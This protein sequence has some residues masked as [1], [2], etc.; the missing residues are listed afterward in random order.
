MPTNIVASPLGNSGYYQLEV[1]GDSNALSYV[2]SLDSME[3]KQ[4]TTNT[5]QPFSGGQS[6]DIWVKSQGICDWSQP[7]RQKVDIP[8]PPESSVF[9]QNFNV[10][11]PI[12]GEKVI[13]EITVY[14]MMGSLIR[15]RTVLLDDSWE[16][17][18]DGLISGVYVV[19]YRDKEGKIVSLN[20]VYVSP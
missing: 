16:G 1:E 4:T 2:W 11:N 20:K 14:N 19:L 12:S 8:F 6:I 18:L 17:I 3:W 5:W 10:S 7:Y 13:Q 15:R 9:S